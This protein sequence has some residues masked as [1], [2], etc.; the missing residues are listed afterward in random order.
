M[1]LIHKHK[2]KERSK[3]EKAWTRHPAADGQFYFEIS[4]VREIAF[5]E[6]DFVVSNWLRWPHE[7][8]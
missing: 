7:S 8:N 4:D 1:N 6:E 5:N 3:Q 2:T